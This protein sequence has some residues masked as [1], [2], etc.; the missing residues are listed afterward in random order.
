MPWQTN[1]QNSFLLYGDGEWHT[2]GPV[3]VGKYTQTRQRL[4]RA[5]IVKFDHDRHYKW[6]LAMY[7][8]KNTSTMVL[9]I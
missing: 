4:L 7:R 1:K 8:K 3:V 6:A 9:R 5:K 2:N